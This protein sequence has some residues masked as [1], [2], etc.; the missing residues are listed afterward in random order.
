MT[1]DHAET[2]LA[3][4]RRRRFIDRVRAEIA[5][6]IAPG[7]LGLAVSGGGDSLAMLQ[8]LADLAPGFGWGLSVA[9]VDHGLRP[10]AADEARMVARHCAALGVAHQTLRWDHGGAVRGNLM[11]AAR[12]A[13]Y[14]LL[15]DWAQ[16]LGR[17]AVAHTADD[18]AETLLMGLSRAAGLDGL[19]GLRPE[20]TLDGVR[21]IRPFL[22]VTR[23]EMQGFLVDCGVLWADDPT[24]DD[25][26]F[27]RVRARRAM[28]A[29]RDLGV[30]PAKM[31]RV[32]RNLAAVQADLRGIVADAAARVVTETAGALQ[33]DAAGVAALPDEVARRLVQAAVL[34][35][36]GQD[37]PP[38]GASL[39]R[40][41]VALRAGRPATLS[42]CRLRR[43]L[44]VREP[45]ALGAPVPLGQLWDGR[46]RV[47]GPG[48]E[49]R[50]LGAEGLAQ[51]PDW[52]ARGIARDAAL[53]LPGVWAAD[54][55]V[56]APIL[57][58]GEEYAATLAAGF[59]LFLLSH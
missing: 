4:T 59:G 49:V 13:R 15:A 35:L 48:G 5:P 52:R 7:P 10:E 54:R 43:G 38:R 17:V 37:H 55:L 58:F 53:V 11:E 28:L 3:Q 42:G 2:A 41:V 21:F 57:T 44:M 26:A 1:G 46:W 22:A 45:R 12:R 20:W 39:A 27:D 30:T 23:A 29:L 6:Q 14:R 34:W 16:D 32:A 50:A 25:P 56:A 40:F 51:V 18:Q 33:F 24:N 31:A 9:T 36:S 8:A 47:T 19:A